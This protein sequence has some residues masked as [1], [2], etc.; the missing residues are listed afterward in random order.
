MQFPDITSR[1]FWFFSDFKHEPHAA[2]RSGQS[3]DSPHCA[4]FS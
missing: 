3:V 1:Q 2:A 4:H